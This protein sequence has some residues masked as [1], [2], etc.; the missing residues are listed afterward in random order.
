ME[1]AT[2]YLHLIQGD[3]FLAPMLASYDHAARHA[4]GKRVLDFGCGYGWGSYMLSPH[5]LAVTG[6]DPDLERIQFARQT[7][8]AKNI[9]LHWDIRSLAGR[10]YDVVCLFMVLP[11][12]A[13]PAGLLRQAGIF[14]KPKG[15]MWISFRSK[16]RH[17]K[18]CLPEAESPGGRDLN[19]LLG[20][21]AM[22]SGFTLVC[23][24]QRFLSA[25]ENLEEHVYH[26]DIRT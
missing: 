6:F 21:W 13:D 24:E 15:T 20:Q 16:I 9:N 19:A 8:Q 23:R 1:T 10:T 11:H 12:A 14:L 7:F 17:P 26:K 5:C 18:D 2:A 4:C 22:G 3:P 25:V